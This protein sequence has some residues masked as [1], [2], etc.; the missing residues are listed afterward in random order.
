[1]QRR[2]ISRNFLIH[3]II[4]TSVCPV[5]GSKSIGE[6][7]PAKSLSVGS[8]SSED[9][10][11]QSTSRRIHKPEKIVL[12]VLREKQNDNMVETENGAT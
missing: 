6:A 3:S 8:Y 10:I 1:M 5:L 2:I 4:Y 11:R 9:E 7:K 12:L